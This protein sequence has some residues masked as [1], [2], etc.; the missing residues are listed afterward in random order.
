M[1]WKYCHIYNV[2]DCCIDSYITDSVICLEE[3]RRLDVGNEFI[4]FPGNW[5]V[6]RSS[7]SY[8][9][10]RHASFQNFGGATLCRL[11]AKDTSRCVRNCSRP[12]SRH[13]AHEKVY[14]CLTISLY[15]GMVHGP[16]IW[17]IIRYVAP[18][19]FPVIVL[20]PPPPPPPLTDR[21]VWRGWPSAHNIFIHH[22]F[23]KECYTWYSGLL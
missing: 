21:S 13:R 7:N 20:I 15:H 9:Q 10:R 23:R 4:C 16:I 1:R 19:H 14:L 12:Q 2:T 6:R 11:S 18:S 8:D 3:A 22:Q 5:S 17:Y